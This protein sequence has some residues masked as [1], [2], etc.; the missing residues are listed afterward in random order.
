MKFQIVSKA[1]SSL[2]IKPS[3]VVLLL[4]NLIPIYGVYYLGWD[5]GHI[6][7]LYWLESGVIGFY[8]LLKIL[9][10]SRHGWTAAIGEVI[11]F[12]LRFGVFMA[13]HL[14]ALV[15]MF[16]GNGTA[17]ILAVPVHSVVKVLRE[18]LWPAVAMLVSHGI[19]YK[20]NF[21][22]RAFYVD[23]DGKSFSGAVYGRVMIMHIVIVIGGN[24][25]LMFGQPNFFIFLL[26][27][28]KTIIDL[29]AHIKQNYNQ[30]V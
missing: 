4:T 5:V 11:G 3:V 1:D 23:S 14:F 8:T 12:I 22:D 9:I 29:R 28:I 6:L 10:A 25:V 18:L 27:L 16:Y 30:S 26:I 17:D 19:S 24:I 20:T 21:L 15:S 13:V 2:L 7:F